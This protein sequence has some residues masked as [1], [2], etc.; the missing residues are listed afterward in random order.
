MRRCHEPAAAAGEVNT[1]AR[2][3]GITLALALA[4]ALAACG[5]QPAAPA[6]PAVAPRPGPAAPAPSRSDGI[7]AFERT[8]RE[9]AETAQR[10]GRLADA[11][12]SWE[13]LTALK[14]QRSE[15]RER[16]ATTRAQIQAALDDRLGKGAAAHKRGELDAAVQ[17]YL[18]A[19]ALEP[20]H[21]GA[22][23]ALRGI[24]RERQKRHVGRLARD[25]LQRRPGGGEMDPRTQQPAAPA[26]R[27]LARPASTNG[28]KA[29]KPPQAASNPR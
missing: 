4:G 13:V 5:S 15:Y 16:L 1:V 24:E 8:H 29:A 28:D 27:G 17:H 14:P 2:A 22:A 9:R 21:E 23:D 25:P 20:T 6:G 26:T 11:A 12:L 10:Q 18:A 19:L 7:E 3:A